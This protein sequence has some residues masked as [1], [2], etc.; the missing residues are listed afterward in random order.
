MSEQTS[1]QPGYATEPPRYATESRSIG[2]LAKELVTDITH[3]FRQE[4]LLVQT[5]A[6]EKLSQVQ[7]GVIS[8]AAGL[9]VGIAALI[10]LLQALVVALAD[11]MEPWL[12]AL[13]V[14][15]GRSE[16]C[17]VGEEGCS[18]GRSRWWGE[19]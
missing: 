2:G 16:E 4:W 1:D 3:L 7:A 11:Y 10:I 17:S 15:V 18:T 19:Y 6:R 9:L 12:A 8:L 13:I 5:E 14:G